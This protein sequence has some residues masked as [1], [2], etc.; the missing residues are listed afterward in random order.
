MKAASALV[1]G[2]EFAREEVLN[3]RIII[4]EFSNRLVPAKSSRLVN[5]GVNRCQFLRR[6][7]LLWR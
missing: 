4:L 6:R 1:S 7:D 3:W 5:E 2:V